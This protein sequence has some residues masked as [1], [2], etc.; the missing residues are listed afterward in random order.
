MRVNRPIARFAMNHRVLYSVI[1]MG[2]A[3]LWI[4]FLFRSLLIG[5]LAGVSALVMQLTLWAPNGAMRKYCEHR[6]E[7]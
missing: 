4:A 5:A 7:Q 1:S 3:F 2:V 6:L